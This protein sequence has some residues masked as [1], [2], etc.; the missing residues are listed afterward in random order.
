MSL[1][2]PAARAI[3][4]KMLKD[5][6]LKRMHLQEEARGCHFLPYEI[7]RFSDRARK[8]NA[9]I[10]VWWNIPS[11]NEITQGQHAEMVN[12]Q[13]FSL[14]R[15]QGCTLDIGD[16]DSRANFDWHVHRAVLDFT[17][18]GG[19]RSA[20]NDVEDVDAIF[21]APADRKSAAAGN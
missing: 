5:D 7:S 4:V 13:V 3:A 15:E 9:S 6:E 11:T 16:P 18:E 2:E 21:G 19:R 10:K 20:K 17:C 1:S 14:M 12:G 8:L